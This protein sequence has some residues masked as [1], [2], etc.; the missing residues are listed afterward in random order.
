M[1]FVFWIFIF[2]ILYVYLGYTLLLLLLRFL[3]RL[4]LKKAFFYSNSFEPDVTIVIAAYNE[5]ALVDEKVRNLRALNYPKEK[6]K[7]LWVT[8][9]S[10]DG[11]PELLQTYSDMTVLHE[12]ARNGK[13]GAL[14]RAMKQVNT[15]LVIFCDANNFLSP[16]T[17]QSIVNLFAEPDVGCVAGEKRIEK[18]IKDKAVGAGEGFYWHY[19]S[20]IKR[21]ES[22]VN[23]TVGAAGEIFAI[24]SKLFEEVEADTLLDDFVISL[25]IAQKGYKI[26]YAPQAIAVETSS[27]SIDDELKRKIRIAAG[28]MQTIPRLLPLLNPFQYGFFS[29]Q[30]WSHKVLRWTLVPFA[31]MVLLPLNFYLVWQ[32]QQSVYVVFLY[33]QLVFYFFAAS[34]W[35]LRKN[36]VKLKWLFLPYYLVVMNYALVLGFFRYLKGKQS[37]NWEKAK[38]Q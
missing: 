17:I 7:F 20:L 6:L 29:I 14:H 34:G 11:S 30:Y 23:S 26:K 13:I 10:N 4:F 21:L 2:L 22:K 38:R 9:G 33:L 35:L 12:D 8:D 18:L 36:S 31:M 28:C 24:R 37:V 32:E 16:Q 3:K 5:K 1:S 27:A 25:R 15:S 19:E